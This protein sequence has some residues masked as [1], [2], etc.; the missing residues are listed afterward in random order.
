MADL[1][2]S[3]SNL[4]QSLWKFGVVH[5]DW[6]ENISFIV[7][8]FR[9]T[10][11]N[12]SY[13]DSFTCALTCYRYRKEMTTSKSWLEILIACTLMSFGGTTL[14]GILLGQ[15]P[16]W[17]L[18][19]TTFPALLLTY[20]LTFHCP[21]DLYWNLVVNG[22]F[23][24]LALALCRL[25]AAVS[26]GYSVTTRGVDRALYNT[27][28]V[29]V[30]QSPLTCI[31]AGTL[32]TC[33]GGLLTDLLGILR[34]PSFT[35]SSV[36]SFFDLHNHKVG[37]ILTRAFLLSCLYYIVSTSQYMIW[38]DKG[39][40]LLTKSNGHFL[41][42]LCQLVQFVATELFNVELY[43]PLSHFAM[44]VLL[45]NPVVNPDKAIAT[46]APKESEK[47]SGTDKKEEKK[48]TK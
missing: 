17:M 4:L 25:V 26:S 14:V 43:V 24:S 18:N 37:A 35:I 21:Y 6:F 10:T 32:A 40:P 20:W 41:I 46:V 12:A 15:T 42:I 22:P 34:I 3:T 5:C 36:P 8:P 38:T 28:N 13:V 33:G 47:A 44:R 7:L 39:V 45:L 30:S 19:P 23:G 1:M 27:F 11:V 48:K 31:V 16:S 29:R 9:P 2:E